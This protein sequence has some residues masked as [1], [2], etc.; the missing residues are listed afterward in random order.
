M[1]IYKLLC[2]NCGT[3]VGEIQAENKV[4]L[5]DY[6]S[7]C[8]DCASLTEQKKKQEEGDLLKKMT[9]ENALGGCANCTTI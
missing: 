3:Q 8:D 5:N 2:K 7:E 1:N 9:Y 4:N 6:N